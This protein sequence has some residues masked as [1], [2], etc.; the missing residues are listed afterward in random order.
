MS[1]HGLQEI[2]LKASLSFQVPILEEL[3]LVWMLIGIVLMYSLEITGS[4]GKGDVSGSLSVAVTSPVT[5]GRATL[6]FEKED[7]TV[8]TEESASFPSTLSVE[9]V[10]SASILS[11]SSL[12]HFILCIDGL[13][14]PHERPVCSV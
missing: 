5:Y 7:G 6:A 2:E 4:I 1:M 14:R 12:K 8:L 11:V 10:Q 9:D 13:D 3:F